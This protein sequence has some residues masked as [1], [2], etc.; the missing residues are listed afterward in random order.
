MRKFLLSLLVV[1]LLAS[2]VAGAVSAQ[3]DPIDVF[4][5]E[6][7]MTY[8]VAEG[9]SLHIWWG[10]LATTRG[11]VRT[12]LNAWTAGYQL[13]D[14]ATGDVVWALSPAE[15]HARW[16]PIMQLTPADV[17]MICASPFHYASD[18][19]GGVFQLPAGTYEL[20]TTWSQSRPV[21]DGWHTCA[22]ALTGEPM[23]YP[24]SLW[25]PESGSWTVTIVVEP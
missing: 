20:V 9:D 10:W 11:L 12:Y 7:G 17:G 3:G 25:R 21:N 15:A 8:T 19:E 13:V 16:S 14:V 23:A 18:W 6:D 2:T 24:P 5:F 4:P 1:I 22:D